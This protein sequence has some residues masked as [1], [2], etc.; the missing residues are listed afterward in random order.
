VVGRVGKS[1]CIPL[2]IPEGD[3]IELYWKFRPLEPDS[4]IAVFFEGKF[5]DHYQ[6]RFQSRLGISLSDKSCT[7]QIHKLQFQD[8]G[9]HDIK[10]IILKDKWKLTEEFNL[11]VYEAVS[12]ISLKEFNSTETPKPSPDQT[13]NIT[14]VCSVEKGSHVTFIWKENGK[15][16]TK[17]KFLQVSNHTT[18]MEIVLKHEE[19][20][21][22]YSCE[23]HNKVSQEN[24]TINPWKFC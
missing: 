3:V 17:D 12:S 4:L 9:I 16:I 7:L 6:D 15:N 23:V 1:V 24:A 21:V 19:I 8:S 22:T 18:K 14:I 5:Y 11:T 13:C 10:I 20:N 2:E